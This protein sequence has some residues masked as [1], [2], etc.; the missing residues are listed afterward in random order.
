MN[1]E[2][3]RGKVNKQAEPWVPCL[4]GSAM[5]AL[6]AI[7]VGRSV[8]DSIIGLFLAEAVLGGFAGQ[9]FGGFA[10]PG[11]LLAFLGWVSFVTLQN[12]GG[13][14]GEGSAA[15]VLM[16]IGTIIFVISGSVVHLITKK[17]CAG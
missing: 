9:K 1:I 11:A 8:F 17:W 5:I 15:F 4:I 16:S 2:T 12:D 14:H 10:L 13:F 3:D 6:S 7:L